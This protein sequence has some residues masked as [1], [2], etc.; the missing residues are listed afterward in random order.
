ML[1]KGF[2]MPHTDILFQNRVEWVERRL[3]EGEMNVSRYSGL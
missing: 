1:I 3:E 2:G